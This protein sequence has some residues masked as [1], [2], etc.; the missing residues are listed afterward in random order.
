MILK[1][2]IGDLS[3]FGKKAWKEKIACKIEKKCRIC[4]GSMKMTILLP[5]IYLIFLYFLKV[6]IVQYNK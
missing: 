6:I 3:I 5:F 2:G 1:F 4:E